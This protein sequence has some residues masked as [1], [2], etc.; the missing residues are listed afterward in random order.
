MPHR[1]IEASQEIDITIQCSTNR[2]NMPCMGQNRGVALVMAGKSNHSTLACG[3]PDWRTCMTLI[4]KLVPFL[5]PLSVQLYELGA[6][7]AEY[8]P[9]GELLA[10]SDDITFE[11][12]ARYHYF[13]LPCF[14]L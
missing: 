5:F 13:S 10:E 12:G 1:S 2:T 8:E 14:A 11:C 4:I 9:D 3:L 6:K 7:G